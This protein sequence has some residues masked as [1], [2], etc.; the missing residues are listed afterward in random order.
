[1]IPLLSNRCIKAPRHLS[2]AAAT[3]RR[4]VGQAVLDREI[5]ARSPFSASAPTAVSQQTRVRLVACGFQYK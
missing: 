5:A 4:A 2:A 1:M 3:L